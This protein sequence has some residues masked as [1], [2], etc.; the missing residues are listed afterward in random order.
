[1]LAMQAMKAELDW[2]MV[3]VTVSPNTALNKIQFLVTY[4]WQVQ[5]Y[6][7]RDRDAPLS[8][9]HIHTHTLSLCDPFGATSA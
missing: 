8:F 3:V 6:L 2:T 4:R 1:M 5:I 9:T 7:C